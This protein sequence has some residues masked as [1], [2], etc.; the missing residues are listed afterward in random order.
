MSKLRKGIA[1][2][3]ILA[4][5][6]VFGV[7]LT[8]ASISREVINSD[9][10]LSED[11]LVIGNLE[12]TEGVLN[13]NGYTLKVQGDLIQNGGIVN[14]NGGNLEVDGD[15]RIGNENNYVRA[16]LTM[17]NAKDRVFVG[18]SFK[19]YSTVI[20]SRHLTSG[21]IEIKGD[22]EQRNYG[23]ANSAHNFNTSGSHKVILSGEGEQKVTF[24]SP[25]NS[26]FNILE[27]NNQ[28]EK[29]VKFKSDITLTELITNN[30]KV[31]TSISIMANNWDLKGNVEYHGDIHLKSGS[32]SL[33]G[34]NLK[35]S[36][37]LMQS[38][39]EIRIDGGKLE[40]DGDYSIGNENNYVSSGFTMTNEEDRVLIGGSFKFYS[41]YNY[42]WKLTAGEMEIRGDFEQKVD[43]SASSGRHFH[44]SGS[45]KVILSGEG[46]QK[47]TFQ[48]PDKSTFNILE[49]K[50]QSEEGV[51][52]KSDIPLNDLIT[53]DY[54]AATS[55]PIRT[56]WILKRDN[57]YSGEIILKEG[58]INLNG[59]N[60][61]ISGNLIQSGGTVN[62]NGGCLE[63]GGDYIIQGRG[64]VNI[65]GG[66]L[67]VGGDYIMGCEDNYVNAYLIMT[68]KKDRVFI[69]GSFK[70]YSANNHYWNLTA[71]TMEIKGDFEQRD[72]KSFNSRNNFYARGSHKV[73]LSGETEQKVYFQTP[74][75]SMFNILENKNQSEKG[76][77][78]KNGI[79]FK[80][81]L[82][83]NS[84]EITSPEQ[85]FVD[86]YYYE[87]WKDTGSATMTI[88]DG[89]A[90]SCEWNDTNS[91]LFRK[92]KYFDIESTYKEIEN[93]TVEFDYD[94]YQ[95]EGY[96]YLAVYGLQQVNP[97]RI[98]EYYILESWD[99]IEWFGTFMGTITV[100]DATYDVY[101]VIRD[102]NPN[103]VVGLVTNYIYFSVPNSK[104]T[105]GTVSVIE[106]FK[107][108]ES[109]GMDMWNMNDV[110]FSV[111]GFRSKGRAKVNSVSISIDYAKTPDE[112]FIVGD[113]NGDGEIN[114]IDLVLLRRY[115]LGVISSFDYEY[116]LEAADVNG[117]G[118]I[119]SLDYTI[120]RRYLLEI[121]TEF[122][123]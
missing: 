21:E 104:R 12:I 69:G 76:V 56:N 121:I 71:G 7:C 108:W 67:E 44:P 106:H 114:S 73:I 87:L 70:T 9:L 19:T 75:M 46:E 74:D 84:M 60:L 98:L 92:G 117:D 52:F 15:Y 33:N 35:I 3:G 48:T 47:V 123:V 34:H 89:G 4:L 1:F 109:L 14:I 115:I 120:F 95:P 55:I 119:D 99:S 80:D 39:G 94:Y 77:E 102:Q 41:K 42:D 107:A 113:I 23:S 91:A 78:F 30:Y 81:F 13:L 63:V 57:E 20:H 64:T 38:G 90:F 40:I 97:N 65:N 50:N 88:G 118:N 54:K 72:N 82:K 11:K 8:D 111:E 36:G 101:R 27:I 25:E 93:I 58:T 79:M 29:G 28:S 66:C 6:M 68:N 59:H 110:S 122:K 53:N 17:T 43:E 31:A 2:C 83:T 45:H 112:D 32:I 18:G 5:I 105:S 37:N 61:N 16:I 103:T 116:G 24:Q 26:R 86:D 51:E 10:S 22:F 62:I 96:S 100:D 85:I 49:I